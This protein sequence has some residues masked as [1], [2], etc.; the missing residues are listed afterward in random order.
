M[1]WSAIKDCLR[2]LEMKWNEMKCSAIKDCLRGLEMK[3][4]EMKCNKGLF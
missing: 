3:W 4:N 2:G 1:K